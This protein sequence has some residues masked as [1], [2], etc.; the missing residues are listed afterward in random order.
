MD[1][2]TDQVEATPDQMLHGDDF[3]AKKQVECEGCGNAL[4]V[5]RG[6]R[7]LGGDFCRNCRG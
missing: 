1:T 4:L 2:W 6:N 3:S 7:P 5:P